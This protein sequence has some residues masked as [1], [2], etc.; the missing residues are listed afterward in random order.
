MPAIF[1][2]D[3]DALRLALAG[4][5]VPPA[6]GGAPARAGFDAQGRLWLE[7]EAPLSREMV[8][9]LSRFGATVQGTS[10][11]DLTEVVACWPQLLPLQPAPFGPDAVAAAAVLFALPDAGRLVELVAELHRLGASRVGVQWEGSGVVGWWGGGNTDPPAA[12]GGLERLIPSPPYHS[13]TPPPRVFVLAESP[14]FYSL[15]RAFDRCPDAPRAYVRQA[16]RVWV[17]VGYCHPLAAQIEPP[18]GR[19]ALIRAPRGWELID[20]GPFATGPVSF[21]LPRQPAAAADRLDAPRLPIALRLVPDHTDEPAKLW[22]IREQPFEQLRAL[23]EQSDDRLLARL[24]FAV[25][26]SGGPRMVVLRARP[27]KSGPPVL[28]LRALACRPYLR[29]PNLF[30]PVGQR[31]RPPPRRDVVRQLLAS[32]PDQVTWLE[33]A[34]GGTFT[35]H[36]LPNAAFRPL[37]QVVAYVLDHEPRPLLPRATTQALALPSFGVQAPRP[38]PPRRPPKPPAAPPPPTPAPSAT[39]APGGLLRRLVRWLARGAASA[40]GELTPASAGRPAA[41][42]ATPGV[43]GGPGAPTDA[44]EERRRELEARFVSGPGPTESEVHALWAELANSYAGTNRP[45]DAAVCWLNALWEPGDPAVPGTPPPPQWAWG[46]LRAE[47]RPVGSQP[48]DADLLHWLNGPPTGESVRAVAAYAVWAATQEAPPAGLTAALDRVQRL[49]DEHEAWLPVRAAWL[50]RVALARLTGGDVIGLA[51]ARDRLLE[52]LHDR[53]LSAD[54]NVPAFLRFAGQGSGERAETVRAWLAGARAPIHRWLDAR[55]GAAGP[56][57]PGGE[58]LAAGHDPRLRTFGLGTDTRTTRAYADLILAWGLA[59]LGERGAAD[60]LIAQARGVLAGRDEAHAFLLD[61]FTFRARQALEGRPAGPL[62][63]E[64]LARLDALQRLEQADKQRKE[65]AL[66]YK[67]KR[68]QQ[69]SRVLEPVERVHAAREAVLYAHAE[70]DLEQS[71]PELRGVADRNELA[72]RLGVLVASAGRDP[73]RLPRALATALDLAY[74]A[75]EAFATGVLDRLLAALDGFA[76]AGRAE[77]S[78]AQVAALERGLFVA[79]HFDRA[80]AVRRLVG[81]LDRLLD[82]PPGGPRAEVQDALLALIGQGLRGLRRLGLREE[83]DDL[84][85]RLSE[86]VVPGGDLAA[87]RQ[88]RPQDWPLTLR[89]LLALAGG[90]FY[91]GRDGP[92]G[93]VL[94]VARQQLFAHTLR[95]AEQTDLACAYAQ[96]LGQAPVRLALGRVE[97][98]FGRLTGVADSQITNTH[99]SL[100]RLR[101]VEAAVLAVVTDDFALGPAARRWLDDD[102]YRVRRRIHRDVRAALA[103]S[104]G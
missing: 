88:R 14:P 84:L 51:R 92:A 72:R 99:F 4:G 74:R 39:A 48:A 63:P 78:A 42:Q 79:A 70:D 69:F 3:L 57:P 53:G 45:G 44:W 59:R 49:L 102:E 85:E 21:P 52:R 10:S 22:V 9:A 71:R 91:V 54:L 64:L 30:L 15:L 5:A 86:W 65:Q 58:A 37:D 7:P 16:P 27:G 73:E 98:L 6:V 17:E 55:P 11:V 56:A 104:D 43:D 66:A 35:P 60:G 29:L 96:A 90:W 26:E 13:T 25:A 46:W 82:A 97:E 40:A 12:A 87:A 93:D 81:S 38:L 101:L 32:D 62:P 2:A 20:D 68:L 1:F 28:V 67:V 33:P 8:A 18:A 24:T 103:A 47:V 50:A 75:G 34:G 89:R 76:F 31:L 61:A 94:D 41:A 77:Q 80:E 23:A 19:A 83:S 95:P 100:A 36:A